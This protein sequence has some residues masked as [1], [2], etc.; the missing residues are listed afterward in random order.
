MIREVLETI[1]SKATYGKKRKLRNASENM[2]LAEIKLTKVL[3]EAMPPKK[4]LKNLYSAAASIVRAI[5]DLEA[6]HT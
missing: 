1:E 4:V 5:S 3:M 2:Q 6:S